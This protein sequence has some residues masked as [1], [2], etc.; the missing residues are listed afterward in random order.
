MS[1][2]RYN[3]LM[4]RVT[5]MSFCDRTPNS[6]WCHG[7]SWLMTF[8][9]NILFSWGALFLY[10]FSLNQSILLVASIRLLFIVYLKPK[11][12]KWINVGSTF[13]RWTY[14][15]SSSLFPIMSISTYLGSLRTQG[16]EQKFIMLSVFFMRICIV[17]FT[18]AV[19]IY[20][21]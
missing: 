11:G 17:T 14:N 19:Q 20:N 16:N 18:C 4:L 6:K 8:Y 3:S 7:L 2:A 5:E 9:R 12:S 10:L 13:C 21:I 1:V 15:C